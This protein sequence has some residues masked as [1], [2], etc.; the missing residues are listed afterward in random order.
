MWFIFPSWLVIHF[1]GHYIL[2]VF[3]YFSTYIS[4]LRSR[5]TPFFPCGIICPFDESSA[6]AR[7]L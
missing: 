2:L 4:G 6:Q 3:I 7:G 5:P 1:I